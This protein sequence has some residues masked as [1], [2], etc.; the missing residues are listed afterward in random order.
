MARVLFLE[1]DGCISEQTV[2]FLKKDGYNVKAV[3]RIDLAREYLENHYES[4]DCIITDLNMNDEWLDEY[5]EES[6]GTLLSGWVWLRRFVFESKE[7][8]ANPCPCIIYSGYIGELNRK[9]KASELSI[10]RD[11]NVRLVEK[12][13]ND[14]QG[15]LE[16]KAILSEI[17]K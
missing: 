5:S 16:L 17:F 4:V 3:S 8:I 10:L 13:G 2:G 12:G 14:E 7:Y 6:N 11:H 9:L 1:D 15:Y